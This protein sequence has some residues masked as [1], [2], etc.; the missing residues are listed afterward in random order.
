MSDEVT[1]A[2]DDANHGNINQVVDNGEEVMRNLERWERGRG[3]MSSNLKASD[4]WM[5]CFWQLPMKM[6]IQKLETSPGIQQ[7]SKQLRH[8]LE[9]KTD[10]LH[11]KTTRVSGRYAPLKI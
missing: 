8:D 6:S 11:F 1:D 5:E 4:A 10:I 9:L 2:M 3:T 7:S